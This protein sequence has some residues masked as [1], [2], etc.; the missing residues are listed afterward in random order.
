MKIYRLVSGILFVLISAFIGG[1]LIFNNSAQAL[2]FLLKP[3]NI[4]RTEVFFMF[5]LILSLGY[6]IIAVFQNERI[7]FLGIKIRI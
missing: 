2:D 3:E 1:V 4:D 5:S 6:T 7:P